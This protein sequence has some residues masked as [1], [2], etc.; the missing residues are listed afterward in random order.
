MESPPLCPPTNNQKRTKIAISIRK[1]VDGHKMDTLTDMKSVNGLKNR[2][3]TDENTNVS[4]KVRQRTTKNRPKKQSIGSVNRYSPLT[5]TRQILLR[6]W[7]PLTDIDGFK[8]GYVLHVN[9]VDWMV[10]KRQNPRRS[11]GHPSQTHFVHR[12]SKF[13][14]DFFDFR[15][16][17]QFEI[18]VFR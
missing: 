12:V 9:F 7:N 1:S 6:T 3:N 10:A 17:W 8:N 15:V 18:M 2:Q 14:Y 13:F 5:N 11:D 16:K 4:Y